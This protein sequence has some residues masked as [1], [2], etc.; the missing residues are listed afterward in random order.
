MLKDPHHSR[1]HA[2]LHHA[3]WQ[4]QQEVTFEGY[5]E[6]HRFLIE[7]VLSSFGQLLKKFASFYFKTPFLLVLPSILDIKLFIGREQV[8]KLVTAIRWE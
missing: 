2:G 4:P 8:T 1:Q 6:T 7:T 5:F 3:V